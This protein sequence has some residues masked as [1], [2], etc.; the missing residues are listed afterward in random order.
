MEIEPVI[1]ALQ[2]LKKG[3]Y[4]IALLESIKCYPLSYKSCFTGSAKP[5]LES[6]IYLLVLSIV[7]QV[8]TE[9]TKKSVRKPVPTVDLVL[10]MKITGLSKSM[11]WGEEGRGGGGY[12]GTICQ[13][14]VTSYVFR[15]G[16]LKL[17]SKSCKPRKT[18]R[19]FVNV[20]N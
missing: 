13:H 14:G 1:P 12:K 8:S 16:I 19:S 5:N 20:S 3:L 2:E 18:I 7:L 17:Q 9:M 4:K 6:A 11:V 15:W 10:R